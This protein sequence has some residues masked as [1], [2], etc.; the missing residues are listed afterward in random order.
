VTNR[1]N[2]GACGARASR[3]ASFLDGKNTAKL[4]PATS[5]FKAGARDAALD[6]PL[7]AGRTALS[8]AIDVAIDGSTANP[9]SFTSSRREAG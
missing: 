7:H 3:N 9:T 4:S 2:P 8:Q 6:G 1:K 5:N